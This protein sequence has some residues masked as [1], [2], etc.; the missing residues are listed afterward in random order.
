M[1]LNLTKALAFFD[2]ESTGLNVATDRILELAILKVLPDNSTVERRWL[3]NPTILIPAVVSKLHGIFDRDVKEKPTFKMLAAEIKDFFKD[4]DLAGYN[5]LTFDIPILLQEFSRAGVRFKLEGRRVVDVQR[6]FHLMEP[7]NLAAAYKFYCDKELKDA[8]SA[9][10]DITA[11]FEILKAQLDYYVDNEQ[12]K[13]DMVTL[14]K[15]SRHKNVDFLGR[16]VYDDNDKIIFNFGKYKGKTVESIFKS[17][18]GPSYF[19]WLMKG[20]FTDDFK[21]TI[22]ELKLKLKFGQSV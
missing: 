18:N 16:L 2:I 3:I 14:S 10:A 9:R 13:N 4:C 22:T 5:L 8:H 17:K 6:I 15:L 21:A 19:D 20:D 11:T 1:N 12:V 7:R